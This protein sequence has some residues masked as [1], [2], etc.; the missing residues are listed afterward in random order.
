MGRREEGV[1]HII[2][3]K[4]E[5]AKVIDARAYSTVIHTNS[6]RCSQKVRTLLFNCCEYKISFLES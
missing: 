1:D 2:K 5:Q 6:Q 4:E 3:V